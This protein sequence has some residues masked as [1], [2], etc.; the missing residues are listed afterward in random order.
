MEGRECGCPEW[1][2]RC[3]H[4]EGRIV[5][6]GDSCKTRHTCFTPE[7]SERYTT[8]EITAWVPC[9]SGC[10]DVHDERST[11]RYETFPDIQEANAEFDKREQELLGVV[12]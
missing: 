8:G 10:P 3:A 5:H 6:L 9:E 1:V 2:I 7:R 12:L 4:F 11:R